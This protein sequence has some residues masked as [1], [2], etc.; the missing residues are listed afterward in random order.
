MIF[1]GNGGG[2]F[3]LAKVHSGRFVRVRGGV[4]LPAR[5]WAARTGDLGREDRAA[6]IRGRSGREKAGEEK[7]GML[8]DVIWGIILGCYIRKFCV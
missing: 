3:L 5:I 8:W 7:H 1:L 6:C 4:G 2:S